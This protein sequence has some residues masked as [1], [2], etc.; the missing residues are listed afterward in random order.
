MK[1]TRRKFIKKSAVTAVAMA[2]G[3]PVTGEREPPGVAVVVE[4][5]DAN[6]NYCEEVYYS[7]LPTLFKGKY[8][9]ATHDNPSTLQWYKE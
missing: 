1:T 4:G 5:L 6:G 9:Y 3:V 8:Y 7:V 2:I